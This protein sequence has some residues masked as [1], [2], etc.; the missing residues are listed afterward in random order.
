[1]TDATNT[2]VGARPWIGKTTGGN[3]RPA[4]TSKQGPRGK[5]A[6]MAGASESASE[7]CERTIGGCRRCA[8]YPDRRCPACAQRRRRAMQLLEAGVPVGE[9]AGKL[10]LSIPRTK[11][12]IEEEEL[13]RDLSRHQCDHIPVAQIR[14]LFEQRRKED[15]GLTK[16]WLARE[17]KLDRTDLLRALGL[18]KTEARIRNGQRQEGEY[19][20]EVNVEIAARIVLALGFDLHKVPGL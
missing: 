15:P 6:G 1:M 16:S 13:A 18:A 7:L 4:P 8:E 2:A 10:R 5:K 19:Q 14:A 9:I 3:S 17:A 11:R 20:T 12:Y